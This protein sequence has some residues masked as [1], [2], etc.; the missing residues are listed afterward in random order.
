M[1][2]W[3]GLVGWPIADG[4]RSSAGQGKYAGRRPAFYYWA[5]QPTRGQCWKP[6]VERGKC[7]ECQT[8]LT[9]TVNWTLFDIPFGHATFGILV[10]G[11]P[12]HSLQNRVTFAFAKI[13]V[14]DEDDNDGGY[15]RC[16]CCYYYY[17]YYYLKLTAVCPGEHG[18]VLLLHLFWKRNHEGRN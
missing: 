14:L 18:S 4:Y 3:V 9:L 10:F 17:Y 2:D 7:P 15:A 6:N 1:K 11:T 5:T 8:G 13:K 16:C 12:G